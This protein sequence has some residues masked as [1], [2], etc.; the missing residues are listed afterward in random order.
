[1]QAIAS[2]ASQVLGNAVS[3][4]WSKSGTT[5]DRIARIE[6][7]AKYRV[8]EKTRAGCSAGF[9]VPALVFSATPCSYAAS[10]FRSLS[11]YSTLR[12]SAVHEPRQRFATF[13]R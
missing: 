12:W 1:M 4:V 3:G 13:L 6:E 11:R 8:S 5:A 10:V 7:S 9:A 2:V